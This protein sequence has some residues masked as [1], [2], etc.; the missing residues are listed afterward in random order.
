MQVYVN[1]LIIANTVEQR[2]LDLQDRKQKASDAA[3]GE[4]SGAKLKRLTVKDLQAVRISS[5]HTFIV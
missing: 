3:L 1:R 4:G 5:S 2:I